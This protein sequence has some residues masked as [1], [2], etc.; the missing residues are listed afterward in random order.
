MMIG[1]SVMAWML[2][3]TVCFPGETPFQPRD[4]WVFATRAPLDCTGWRTFEVCSARG[5][6]PDPFPYVL[7]ERR[8]PFGR[9]E[10]AI[11]VRPV[12][13]LRLAD[14]DGDGCDELLAGITRTFD[15]LDWRRLYV[16]HAR[17]GRILPKWLGSRLSY[18]LID[19]EP[20]R[21][22]NSS[23]DKPVEIRTREGHLGRVYS[24][25]YVWRDWGFRTRRLKEVE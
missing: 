10:G 6:H 9:I 21:V 22:E 23:S 2:W 4:V 3:S 25:T 1:W 12:F 15:G 20:L 13:K 17:D 16:Y 18:C 8:F 7:A 5:K 19:F 14:I 11:R 24:G